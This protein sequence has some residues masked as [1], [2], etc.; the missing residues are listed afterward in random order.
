M[1]D[2]CQKCIHGVYH[3]GKD[4]S[5]VNPTTGKIIQGG[6][7]HNGKDYSGGFI[8]QRERL[9]RGVSHNTE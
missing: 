2:F 5:G 7:S 1:G 6:V 9:F 3:N 4:Y 8:P